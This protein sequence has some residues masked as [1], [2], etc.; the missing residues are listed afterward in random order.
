MIAATALALSI[1]VALLIFFP[2]WEVAAFYATTTTACIALG[3]VA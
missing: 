3:L 1:L 2:L